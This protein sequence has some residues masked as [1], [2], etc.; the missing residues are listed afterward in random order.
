M[1]QYLKITR[2]FWLSIGVFILV[3]IIGIFIN[4]MSYLNT[5]NFA[6]SI[7]VL[8]DNYAKIG[9]MHQLWP[10][11]SFQMTEIDKIQSDRVILA[12]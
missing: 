2:T 8:H 5:N 9:K 12:Q 7:V 1:L 4:N 3:L 11:I 10:W 6:A